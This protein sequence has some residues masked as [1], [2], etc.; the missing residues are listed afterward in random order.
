MKN[1]T[2]QGLTTKFDENLESKLD[3]N[4]RIGK[5]NDNQDFVARTNAILNERFGWE[6]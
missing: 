5:K 1:L 2:Y 4:N 6:R 3:E